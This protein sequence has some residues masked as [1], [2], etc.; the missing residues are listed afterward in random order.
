MKKLFFGLAASLIFC[1]AASS[2]NAQV[3]D[4][5]NGQKDGNLEKKV[6]AD[7][8]QADTTKE[9]PVIVTPVPND[10]TPTTEGTTDKGLTSPSNPGIP[11]PPDAP[12]TSP[13]VDPFPKPQSDI[14]NAPRPSTSPNSPTTPTTGSPM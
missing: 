13:G 7:T 2:A 10:P 6:Q 9:D 5:T 11:T 8:I 3:Q 12:S 14:P 4:T 1:F